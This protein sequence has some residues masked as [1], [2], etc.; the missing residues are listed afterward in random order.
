[1][2][3]RCAA[4]SHSQGIPPVSPTM[5]AEAMFCLKPSYASTCYKWLDHDPAGDVNF[6]KKARSELLEALKHHYH[7]KHLVMPEMAKD[8]PYKVKVQATKLKVTLPVLSS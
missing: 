5:E 4:T 3:L 6:M 2:I 7:L 8:A 1:M